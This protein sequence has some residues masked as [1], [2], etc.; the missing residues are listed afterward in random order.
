M[1][2]HTY[3]GALNNA[4]GCFSLP[5]PKCSRQAR[6]DSSSLCSSLHP[7]MSAHLHDHDADPELNAFLSSIDTDRLCAA[8]SVLRAR[9]DC[10][11]GGKILGGEW[12]L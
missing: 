2:S 11:L 12:I 9:V 6:G 8:A 5:D 1:I 10:S 3:S 4:L 7:G